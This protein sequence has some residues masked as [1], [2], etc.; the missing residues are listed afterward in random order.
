MKIR[1]VGCLL[2]FLICMFSVVACKKRV[3]SSTRTEQT[4]KAS[5]APLPDLIDD[6]YLVADPV[7]DDWAYQKTA[8]VDLDGDGSEEQILLFANV[9]M[10]G[11]EYCWDDGQTWELRIDEQTGEQTRVYAQYL[12][13]GTAEVAFRRKSEQGSPLLLLLEET[14]YSLRVYEIVYDGPGKI[15]VRVLVDRLIDYWLRNPAS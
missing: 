7:S 9:S 13:F 8:R 11:G 15:R 6:S 1:R 3:A 5:R 10:V 12:Q 2:I 4:A 14:D